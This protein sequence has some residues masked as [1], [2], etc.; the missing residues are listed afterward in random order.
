MLE[1]L[2]PEVFADDLRCFSG[3]IMEQ[4][5]QAGDVPLPGFLQ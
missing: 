3:V 5:Y 4:Q 2:Y 1:H